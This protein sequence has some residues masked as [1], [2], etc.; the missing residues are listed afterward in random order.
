MSL[1]ERSEGVL[2]PTGLGRPRPLRPTGIERLL[3]GAWLPDGK[4]LCIVGNEPGRGTRGYV[5]TLDD[6]RPVPFTDEGFTPWMMIPEPDGRTVLGGG[7][8]GSWMRFPLDGRP[9]TPVPTLLPTDRRVLR[10]S[11]REDEVYTF[12]RNELLGRI[13]KVSL[14]TGERTLWRDLAP[15]DPAGVLV[16]A[17]VAVTPDG[18]AYAYSYSLQLTTVHLVLGLE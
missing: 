5:M 14:A 13:W 1:D 16:Q 10:F 6:P 17:A 9:P 7:S 12:E 18:A 3:W 8:D 4:G 2:V 15:S 11:D